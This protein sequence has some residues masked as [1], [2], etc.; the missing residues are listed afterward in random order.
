VDI[1]VRVFNIKLKELLQDIVKGK[2]FGETLASWYKELIV[3]YILA[4]IIIF[5]YGLNVL[6]IYVVVYTIEFQKRGLPHAHILTF[7]KDRNLSYD[8]S[9]VDKFISAEILD[10]ELDPK[11]YAAVENYMIHGPCGELDRNSVCMEDNKCTKLFS[12]GFNPE[13]TINE[14]GFLVYR[15]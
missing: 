2:R 3:F 10:K 15:R 7:L 12:K 13:T 8:P 5:T 9:V 4:N 11:G 6:F 14:E 1:I